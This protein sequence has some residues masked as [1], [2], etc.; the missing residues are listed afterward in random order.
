MWVWIL[1]VF[2][3]ANVGTEIFILCYL[4]CFAET[5]TSAVLLLILSIN[6]DAQNVIFQ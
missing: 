2:E 3:I 4:Q 5:V 1:F 6:E